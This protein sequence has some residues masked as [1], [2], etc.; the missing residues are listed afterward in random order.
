MEIGMTVHTLCARAGAAALLLF[1][2]AGLAAAQQPANNQMMMSGAVKQACAG[3]VKTLCP[4]VEPGGGR[5]MQCLHENSAKVSPKCK[6][7]LGEA[8]A[9]KSGAKPA[10]H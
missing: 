5:L 8:K 2:G 7:T 6:T 1:A 10:P 3:D 4:G 9:A